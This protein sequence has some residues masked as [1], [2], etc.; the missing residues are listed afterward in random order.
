MTRARWTVA[1]AAPAI[2]LFAGMADPASAATI[3]I[4]LTLPMF[5]QITGLSDVVFANLSPS[6]DAVS[7]QNVCTFSNTVTRS[8]TVVASGSGT[9]AA[10]LLANS[11]RTSVA[12]SVGWAGTSGSTGTTALTAG[13]SSAAFTGAAT[14]PGCTIGSSTTATLK[15]TIAAADLQ[16]MTAGTTYTGTLTLVISPS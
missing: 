11:G 3:P 14:T 16:T 5:V 15:I 7:S 4:S 1:A 6:A 9:G 13:V 10:F 2:A 8:Y 12:Y